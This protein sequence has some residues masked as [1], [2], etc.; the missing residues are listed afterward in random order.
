M[1]VIA[2]RNI[3]EPFI[4]TSKVCG[5]IRPIGSESEVHQSTMSLSSI[6]SF[7]A[8]PSTL[9]EELPMNNPVGKKCLQSPFSRSSDAFLEAVRLYY[10]SYTT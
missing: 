6:S 4:K 10:F 7:I 2:T 3:P 1:V 8:T 9:A 5:N